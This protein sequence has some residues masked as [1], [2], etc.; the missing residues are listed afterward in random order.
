MKTRHIHLSALLLTAFAASPAWAARDPFWPIGY[1]PPT[2]EPVSAEPVAARPE[3]VAKPTEKP[4]TDA[5]WAVARKALVISGFTQTVQPDTQKTR[6]L[7]MVNRSMVA[8]GDTVTF[9]HQDVRFLWRVA[10]LTDRAIELVPLKAE[11]VVPK[12][13]KPSAK[14]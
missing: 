7:A 10:S 14:Q 6:F 3:P 4:I 2:L 8:A 11:R 13:T 9:V 12:P 5:D 1:E